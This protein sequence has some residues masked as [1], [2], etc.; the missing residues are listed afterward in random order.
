[1]GTEHNELIV[2]KKSL[3][4]QAK[5][6]PDIYDEPFADSS[7][8][9]TS[10]IS[11]FAASQLKVMLS[12]DGADEFFGGYNRYIFKRKIEF[13][14]KFF[15]FR[16]RILIG[17]IINIIPEKMIHAF[18]LLINKFLI[19][20]QNYNQMYEKLKKLAVLLI[21]CKSNNEI[22]LKIYSNYG[23]NLSIQNSSA[24]NNDLQEINDF[25][26]SKL[27]NYS[28]N[29]FSSLEMYLDQNIYLSGDIL[30]KVDRASMYYSL[31][32]RSPF[33]NPSV[34]AFANNL[35]IE[36]KIKYGEGKWILRKILNKYIPEKFIQKPKRGFSI[37]LDN[38]M[39]NDL[40]NW[41]NE[42]LNINEI[43]NQGFIN[44]K[45]CQKII[46]DHDNGKNYGSILWN[47]II[48]QSWIK[49]YY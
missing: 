33:L 45:Q 13:L 10:L 23:N 42:I 8:I 36:M 31:E 41:R 5:I 11:K 9:P 40:K 44:Y 16:I 30:H 38:W 12:G 34:I 1:M 6:I 29:G 18:E 43:K 46:T 49:K 21:E 7:Q 26:S 17:Q 37:P 28:K 32:N 14:Y 47:L 2:D 35:P 25:I 19:K 3:L 4:N 27:K 24:T 48:W 22:Y 39:R 15:P 20:N